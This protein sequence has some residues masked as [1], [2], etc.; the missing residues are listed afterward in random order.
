MKIGTRGRRIVDI[1]IL[2][3][4]TAVIL[5]G[6]LVRRKSASP[7][8]TPTEEAEKGPPPLPEG[9]PV[10]PYDEIPTDDAEAGCRFADHGFGDYGAWRSLPLGRALV[11]EGHGLDAANNFRL[12]IH[13][14]GS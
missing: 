10:I 9:A 13:F 8:P 7:S 11:L 4:S 3:L 14:H 1:T 12:L 2:G 6:L 5:T